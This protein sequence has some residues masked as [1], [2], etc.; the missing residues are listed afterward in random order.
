M[1]G[2]AFTLA[3][4]LGSA[5]WVWSKVRPDPTRTHP[6]PGFI[7]TVDVEIPPVMNPDPP[8]PMRHRKKK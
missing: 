7:A 5:L 3:V 2:S 1:L 4:I 6:S 8:P